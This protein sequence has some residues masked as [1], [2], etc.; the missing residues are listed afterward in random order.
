MG[1]W[2]SCLHHQPW[3]PDLDSLELVQGDIMFSDVCVRNQ[4]NANRTW[5]NQAVR[6]LIVLGAVL[7]MLSQTTGCANRIGRLGIVDELAVSYRDA[8]WARRAY[9]L[10]YANCDRPYGDHFENGFCAGYC[11]ISNGEDEFVPA[12]PPDDYRGY[13]FQSADGAQCVAAWFEG[14]PEGVAAAKKDRAG[15]YHDI[16]VSRMIDSAVTQSKAKH[17]LPSD[18]PVKQA[19]STLPST[20][21]TSVLSTPQAPPAP[22]TAYVPPIMQAPQNKFKLAPIVQPSDVKTSTIQPSSALKPSSAVT[23]GSAGRLI[24]SK[25]SSPLKPVSIMSSPAPAMAVPTAPPAASQYVVPAMTVAPK[26]V[27]PSVDPSAGVTRNE[28]PLPMA[29]R[30]AG[31]W[32]SNRRTTR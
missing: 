11:A 25:P 21:G 20:P 2:A 6:R 14:Y 5:S 26:I 15:T 24:P 22:R 7:A 29:V 30:S 8:V 10:R 13:E 4:E 17:V 27:V 19:G 32:Q 12:L 16:Y 23:T 3:N 31:A 28:T 18:V 1:S 9:N